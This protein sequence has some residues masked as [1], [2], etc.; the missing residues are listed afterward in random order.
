MRRQVL[1]KRQ[2][3]ETQRLIA[4]DEDARVGLFVGQESCRRLVSAFFRRA[5]EQGHKRNSGGVG[6]DLDDPSTCVGLHGESERA[7]QLEALLGRNASG[8]VLPRTDK[9]LQNR[10]VEFIAPVRQTPLVPM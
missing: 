10:F 2:M 1:L 9:P 3:P 7:H 8:D 5:W 4:S 6:G